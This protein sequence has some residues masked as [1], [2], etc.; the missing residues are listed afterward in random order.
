MSD[1]AEA[2]DKA[3]EIIEAAQSAYTKTIDSFRGSIKNDVASIGSSADKIQK[4]AAKMAS[5]CKA[6]VDLLVSPQMIA[7]IENAERLAAAL[8][9]ISQVQPNKIAFAVIENKAQ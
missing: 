6:S 8:T 9:A 1:V 7:A 5:A 2:Y 4:E 3:N